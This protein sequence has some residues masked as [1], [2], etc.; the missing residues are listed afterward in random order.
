MFNRRLVAVFGGGD[1]AD[2]SVDHIIVPSDVRMEEVKRAYDQ[3][4]R[5]DYCPALNAGTRPTFYTLPQFAIER[6][7]A[8]VATDAD[9]EEFWE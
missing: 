6:F 2:A 3:W 1:W 4:Y 9:I 5:N 8:A 7:G